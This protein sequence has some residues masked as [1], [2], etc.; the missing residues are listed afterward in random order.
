MPDGNLSSPAFSD[1]TYG[2]FLASPDFLSI[3]H[4]TH[5]I[6]N[7][8][9]ILGGPAYYAGLTAKKLG[10]KTGIVTSVGN[11]FIGSP[12]LM[13]I[14]VVNVPASQTTT[15]KNTY[16]DTNHGS[17]RKQIVLAVASRIGAANIP[18]SYREAKVCYVC[19]VA[20]ELSSDVLEAI[21]GSL[22]GIGLQG[23]MRDWNRKGEVFASI[24]E[25]LR[26]LIP[27]ADMV[28]LSD[29]DIKNLDEA[30]IK[31]Y[32]ELANIFILTR[33]RDGS[34]L[35]VKGREYQIDAFPALEVDPTGAGD[36]YG[37]SFL[38]KYYETGNPVRAA[39]FASIVASFVVEREG[40]AGIP[41]IGSIDEREREYV[42]MLEL[43]IDGQILT[44]PSIDIDDSSA[45]ISAEDTMP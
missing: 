29:E 3:G 13:G 26:D 37:A 42:K 40:T 34:S 21:S 24:R 45:M 31:G 36:V 15:F 9:I 28:I 39:H 12:E 41:D 33:G 18:G 7:G 43:G 22:I 19:P 4:I 32:I 11:D 20:N 8:G 27:L 2:D 16:I 1:F 6:V 10:L 14:G 44:T 23:W 30:L 25:D 5:D 17:V 35:F 38:I